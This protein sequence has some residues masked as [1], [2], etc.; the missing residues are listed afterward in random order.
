[1]KQRWDQALALPPPFDPAPEPV[2]PARPPTHQNSRV[3]TRCE[4]EP[5]NIGSLR[6]A[7]KIF[8][9][10]GLYLLVMPSGGRYW[11]YN[12]RF[13]GKLKT[14]SLGVYPDV[15]LDNARARHQVARTILADGVDPSARKR[16]LGNRVFAMPTAG[17]AESGLRGVDLS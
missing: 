17:P 6:C 15:S 10:R 8:D 2:P 9:G 5:P 14:L 11:R 16:V 3:K 7:R 13:D 1:M 12:Y 4:T